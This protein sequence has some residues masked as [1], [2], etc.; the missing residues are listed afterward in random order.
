MVMYFIIFIFYIIYIYIL[1]I[2]LKCF[3]EVTMWTSNIQGVD[4]IIIII[5]CHIKLSHLFEDR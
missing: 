2:F 5:I 3:E 1:S 4:I